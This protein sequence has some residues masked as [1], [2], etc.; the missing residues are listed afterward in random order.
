MVAPLAVN[1]AVCPGQMVTEGTLRVG[2]VVTVMLLVAVDEHVPVAP[3]T[4]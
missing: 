3:V 2:V 4:V 1:V